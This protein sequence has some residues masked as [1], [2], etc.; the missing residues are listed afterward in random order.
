MPLNGIV[1]AWVVVA[2]TMGLR[3]GEVCGL[4]WD[5]VD[6]EKRRL[7]VHRSLGWVRGKPELK[8]PKTKR[9]RTLAIPEATAAVLRRHRL[10][11]VE[12][13]LLAGS[14]WPKEWEQLVFVIQRGTPIDPTNLRRFVRKLALDAGID[15]RMTPYDLRH[16]ATS[17]LSAAGVAPELLADLLGHVDTRMVFRHYRHPVTP[18][19]EV[20]ADHIERA[21]DL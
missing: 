10:T 12:E 7:V 14:L 3:T 8:P 17:V 18:A 9:P 21:L 11:Q 20:A 13:R 19:I 6:L 2:L 5:V 1:L 4:T 15:G 16:T